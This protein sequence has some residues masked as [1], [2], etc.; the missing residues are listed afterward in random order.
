MRKA[1]RPAESATKGRGPHTR[2]SRAKRDDPSRVIEVR[3]RVRRPTRAEGRQNEPSR[4]QAMKRV[5]DPHPP[6]RISGTGCSRWADR[7]RG[8]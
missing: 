5:R 4:K 2:P 3:R 7:T 8:A 6:R 1:E